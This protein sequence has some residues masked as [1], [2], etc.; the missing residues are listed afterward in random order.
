MIKIPKKEIDYIERINS[1]FIGQ[2]IEEVFYEVIDYGTNI[3][4]WNF[5]ESIHSIDMNIIFKLE[6]GKLIQIKWDHEFDCYGIGFEQITG[7]ETKD[8]FETINVTENT[9]WKSK[10]GKPISAIDIF[11]D[12]LESQK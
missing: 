1:T 6:N 7:L 10:I 11:W 5:S 8:S 9:N 3:K 4:Y 12:E 2:K